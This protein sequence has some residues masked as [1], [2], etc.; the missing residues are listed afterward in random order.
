MSK[1]PKMFSA[2]IK[3]LL[4]LAAFILINCGCFLRMA[5]QGGADYLLIGMVATK[6]LKD[7]N[8]KQGNK[9]YKKVIMVLIPLI[10]F[11]SII[12]LFF[13]T[14]LGNPTANS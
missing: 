3:A 1:N 12:S 8:N 4:I 9:T 14:S 13:I 7:Y 5:V 10:F 2:L 11:G 6:L